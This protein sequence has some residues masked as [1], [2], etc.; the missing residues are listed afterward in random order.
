VLFCFA[1]GLICFILFPCASPR[2]EAPQKAWLY[3]GLI[4]LDRTYNSVPSL[5]ATFA[6]LAVLYAAYA[7]RDTAR[8][9]LRALLLGIAWLWV[10]LILF[11]TIATR[12]HFAVD[13]V[14]G[15]ILAVVAFRWA[16]AKP[17][18]T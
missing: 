18:D 11:S 8:R 1:I 16:I 9:S 7:S 5:H 14:P 17:R 13:L 12:Q 6:V 15:I 3:N 2:P 4:S 10:G